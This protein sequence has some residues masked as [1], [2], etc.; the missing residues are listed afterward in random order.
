M[1]LIPTLYSDKIQSAVLSVISVSN[2]SLD[3]CFTNLIKNMIT[4]SCFT[5]K[6][7]QFILNIVI[8]TDFNTLNG[9]ILLILSRKT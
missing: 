1:K 2:L 8:L 4:C 5:R 7:Y 3:V 6:I 9:F